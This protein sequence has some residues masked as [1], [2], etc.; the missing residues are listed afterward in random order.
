MKRFLDYKNPNAIT[1]E[2]ML[3]D[4]KFIVDYVQKNG[5]V[6]KLP[7]GSPGKKLP[8]HLH[9]SI[10]ALARAACAAGYSIAEL[11]GEKIQ[12]LIDSLKGSAKRSA[13]LGVLRLNELINRRGEFPEIDIFLPAQPLV[14]AKRCV[15]P[16][17]KYARSS[18]EPCAQLL[19]DDIQAFATKRRGVDEN[20]D[21]IPPEESEFGLVTEKKYGDIVKQ[22]INTLVLEGY[23]TGEETLRLRDI[24]SETMIKA[25]AKGWQRR[26]QSGEVS[27]DADYYYNMISKMRFIAEV[28]GAGKKE[29]KRI[30]KIVDKINGKR[31]YKKRGS[32][33]SP[34][35]KQFV[36]DFSRDYYYQNKLFGSPEELQKRAQKVLDNWDRSKTNERMLAIKMGIAAC[37]NAIL[38]RAS[39]IRRKNLND[40]RFRGENATLI[41]ND[42][43]DLYIFL[44]E[45]MVKNGRSIEH[46]ADK[47]AFPIVKWFIDEVRP[48]W[49]HSH[50]YGSKLVDS[51]YLFP[52]KRADRPLEVETMAD[53]Y[54]QAI[55]QLGLS[56]LTFHLARHISV[57]LILAE[58]PNA[59][60]EAC[61]ILGD[62]LS[63]V[64]DFYAWM[65]DERTHKQGRIYLQNSV[66]NARKYKEGQR[67][68]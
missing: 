24:C 67:N 60:S 29:L 51:D 53:H 34:V 38:Y 16:S 61:E 3:P 17:D 64:R 41:F 47:D 4:G 5:G 40:L 8:P 21:P 27:N 6:T 9:F 25:F 59:W 45:D 7:D 68:A 54:Y 55:G 14:I 43:N 12:E 37:I 63:S 48:K 36:R 33:M 2:S 20:G 18:K 35:R 62:T 11:D 19:W 65:D 1:K 15:K 42:R 52:S 49:I 31:K 22:A 10:G 23:L 57:F 46:E 56:G 50:P 58:N 39:P 13:K 44:S 30:Q 26:I 32:K 28:M 66:K